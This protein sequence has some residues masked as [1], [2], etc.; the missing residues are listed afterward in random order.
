MKK[1]FFFV[2]KKIKQTNFHY[3]ITDLRLKTE[4]MNDTQIRLNASFWK[5]H[6]I[7]KAKKKF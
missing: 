4:R 2:F 6:I 7:T 1:G 5:I 3:L